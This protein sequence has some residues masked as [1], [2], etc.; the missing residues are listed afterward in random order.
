[1][2]E[3]TVADIREKRATYPYHRWW[4]DDIDVLLSKITEQAAEIDQM[5]DR[6]ET[7]GHPPELF[8]GRCLC[9]C[10]YDLGDASYRYTMGADG[11]RG[12]CQQHHK[13]DPGPA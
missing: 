1:M 3:Q 12:C 11:F 6:Q 8:E 10:H 5:R 9:G 13:D 7:L 2:T 4:R